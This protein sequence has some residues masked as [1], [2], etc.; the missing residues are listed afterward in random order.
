MLKTPPLGLKL[1]WLESTLKVLSGGHK[2][3][4][5]NYTLQ[6]LLTSEVR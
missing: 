2:K 6:E 5:Q 4:Q 3:T 1:L